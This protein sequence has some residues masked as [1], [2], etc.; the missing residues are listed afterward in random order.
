MRD[1]EEADVSKAHTAFIFSQAVRSSWS[2]YPDIRGTTIL[3]TSLNIYQSTRR[4]IPS[5]YESS[6]GKPTSQSPLLQFRKNCSLG[7]TK[8]NGTAVCTTA[9][10]EVIHYTRTSLIHLLSSCA[11][12]NKRDGKILTSCVYVHSIVARMYFVATFHIS[13]LQAHSV[14]L[15][16]IQWRNGKDVQRTFNYPWADY[17]ACVLSVNDRKLLF[18]MTE[19]ENNVI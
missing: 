11:A 12:R 17:P 9:R 7:I 8:F 16:A 3:E 15:H 14:A 18:T 10:P 1:P 4:Y 5:R 13:T 2:A 6:S 19:V